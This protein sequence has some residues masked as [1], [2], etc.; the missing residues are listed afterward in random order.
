I[1]V[2]LAMTLVCTVLTVLTYAGHMPPALLLAFTF[3]LGVGSVLTGPASQALIPD[4]VPRSQ[5]P[6]AAAVGSININ[7]AR[8]VGPALAGILISV[9][10]VSSVFA[11]DAASLLVFAIVAAVE[12]L[13]SRASNEDAE[14]FAAA[15]SSGARYV[16]YAPVV[17]RL[18]GRL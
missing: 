6:A 17:L 4:L 5:I 8:A 15:L 18:L 9:A 12:P 2:Q 16:R 13:P 1:T 11:L 7:V 3:V 10:G 14:P